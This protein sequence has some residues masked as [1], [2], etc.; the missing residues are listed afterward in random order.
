MKLTEVGTFD[1]GTVYIEEKNVGVNRKTEI[2]LVFLF[3][4]FTQ[5]FSIDQQNLSAH[6]Q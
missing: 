3:S 4:H 6:I 5:F 2:F 1:D